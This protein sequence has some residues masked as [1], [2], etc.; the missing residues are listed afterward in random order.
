MFAV[1]KTG[2]SS[3]SSGLKALTGWQISETAGAAA[4]VTIRDGSGGNVLAHINIGA[5]QTVGEA[6]GENPIIPD[7]FGAGNFA[8]FFSV[9]S[10]TVR[11][12]A[13]GRA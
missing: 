6:Y 5:N 11:W 8:F 12:T 2:T 7:D 1:V 10:G 3:A 4:V 9:D 13:Y